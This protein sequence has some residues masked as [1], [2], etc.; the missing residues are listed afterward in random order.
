[1]APV[2]RYWTVVRTSREGASCKQFSHEDYKKLKMGRQHCQAGVLELIAHTCSIS[3][4]SEILTP[5]NSPF[6]QVEQAKI[7]LA[8]RIVAG[9]DAST[10]FHFC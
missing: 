10:L 1:M 4:V 7:P 6:I 5:S 2:A 8:P 9:T 3:M